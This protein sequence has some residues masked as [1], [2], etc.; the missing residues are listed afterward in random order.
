MYEGHEGWVPSTYL[1]PC[2]AANDKD[3]DD[4]IEIGVL[5]TDLEYIDCSN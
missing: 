1:E 4:Q 2:S 5:E 3:S